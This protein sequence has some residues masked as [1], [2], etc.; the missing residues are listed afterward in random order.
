MATISTLVKDIQDRLVSGK[1]FQADTVKI[2]AENLA[3]KLANRLSAERSQP[4]L[5]MSNLGTKCDRKLWYSI[6]AQELA[7]PLP[8]S[9]RFKFLFGD[10]IEEL[11]FFLARAAGHKV[12]REQEEVKLDGV[13]G[14]ID[15]FIDD[16]LVDAKSASTYGFKKFKEHGLVSDDPFG[17][18]DQ[19]GGYGAATGQT[20]GHFL[21][22]DKTLGSICLDTHQLAQ[23]D[24]NQLIAEKRKLLSSATT[25][26][27]AYSD[28]ADGK[29]GNRKLG[30]ACSY[31]PFKRD[32]WPGMRTFKY[33]RGPVFLTQVVREPDVPELK[34]G[35][36]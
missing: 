11:V 26:K 27:K 9:T 2:F 3:A 13:V 23:K 8:A 20:R 22:V 12:E 33:S 17:Y 31:C 16:E 19:L 14:H 4:T 1:P 21:A 5:R 36:E 25:P 10:V 30:I 24:Y 18:I 35:E 7:E 34:Y 32:C 6:N 29:S 28:E 15:G